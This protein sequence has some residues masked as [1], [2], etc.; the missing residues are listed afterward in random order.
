MPKLLGASGH[1]PWEQLPIDWQINNIVQQLRPLHSTL[2]SFTTAGAD[3]V[4]AMA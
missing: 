3:G 4:V 1:Q 2:L